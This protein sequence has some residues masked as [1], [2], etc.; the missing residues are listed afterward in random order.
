[1]IKP[2]LF[3]NF[4]TFKALQNKAASLKIAPQAFEG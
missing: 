2:N 1:M 3:C 4:V